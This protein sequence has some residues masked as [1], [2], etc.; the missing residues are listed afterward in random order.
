MG[1]DPAASCASPLGGRMQEP[2]RHFRV[3]SWMAVLMVEIARRGLTNTNR[4]RIMCL[5]LFWHFLNVV[6]IAR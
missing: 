6:W 3:I 2:A 1:P 4:T 5:S